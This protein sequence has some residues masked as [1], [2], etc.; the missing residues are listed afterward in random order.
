MLWIS[1]LTREM[2]RPARLGSIVEIHEAGDSSK[3]LVIC[4]RWRLWGAAAT[5]QFAQ[6]PVL[7]V[8][9]SPAALGVASPAGR[10]PKPLHDTETMRKGKAGIRRQAMTY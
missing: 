9:A 10:L 7:V 5:L 6:P 8:L 1:P 3:R 4:K 2:V